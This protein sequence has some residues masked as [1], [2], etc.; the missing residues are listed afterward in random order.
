MF[1]ANVLDF[2][3]GDPS[4]TKELKALREFQGFSSGSND[5][6]LNAPSQEPLGLEMLPINAKSTLET[7]LRFTSD[8]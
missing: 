2:H 1:D 5:L 6:S 3:N 8:D 4:Q 7:S